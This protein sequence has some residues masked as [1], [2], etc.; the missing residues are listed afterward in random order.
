VSARLLV[1]L[2]PLFR[3]SLT[4]DGYVLR[5]FGRRF[6]PV[7]RANRRR[8]RSSGYTGPERRLAGRPIR[9]SDR[10]AAA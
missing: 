9:A 7:L 1:A 8:R 6:G 4:R 5:V 10:Q 2:W 3:Y